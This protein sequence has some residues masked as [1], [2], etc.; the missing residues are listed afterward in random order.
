MKGKTLWVAVAG[1]AA[2]GVTGCVDRQAQKEAKATQQFVSNPVKLVSVQ[3]VKEQTLIQTQEI[4]GGITTADDASVG[5]KITGRI[6]AV[7]VKDGDPVTAGQIIAVQDT[8]T[9]QDQLKSAMAG[10]ASARANLSQTV[11]N[12]ALTPMKSAAAV[13]AAQAQLRSAKANLDKAKAGARPE[14]RTQ[15]EWQVKSA[16][17]G[18]DLASSN[19]EREKKLFEQGAV[20]RQDLDQAQNAYNSALTAYNGALQSQLMQVNGTRTED[21][22][23]AEEAVRSA[24]DNLKSAQ[25]QQR[26][27]I[28]LDDQVQA[29]RAGVQSA[30][31][32]VSIAQQAIEDASIRAPFS[33]HISGK[34][35]QVGAIAAPGTVV[36]RIVG[37][38][39]A[40]FEG[41]VSEEDIASLKTGSP[42]QIKVDALDGKIFEGQIAAISPL[43]SD[44]GR[45]FN[46]RVSFSGALD[47]IRP[48]MYAKGTIQIRTI[49]NTV[50]L[51]FNAVQ[52]R[53]LEDI[54]FVVDGDKAKAVKVKT[55]IRQQDLIQIEGLTPGQQ[56]VTQGQ[57][58][59]IDGAKVQIDKTG[60]VS[61]S[62]AATTIGG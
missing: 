23:I 29:A 25:A 40:Y 60:S 59:L 10:L 33:G 12:A 30:T 26:L 21:L 41:Q 32:Q 27:D 13:N 44:V 52:K 19:L 36:A 15:V 54:V 16:K 39:G 53:G 42:V 61:A 8:S 57:E 20:S 24:Q 48:G 2:I 49:P 51:P 4:T 14:E 22:A 6:T 56:V 62:L 3:T 35:L 31:A 58:S 47:G 45:L 1:V 37:G 46:V 18:L 5:P 34:P 50:V 38:Q 11:A 43:G 17:S 9:L 55:G 7:Y 28:V